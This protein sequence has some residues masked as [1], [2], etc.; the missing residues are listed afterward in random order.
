VGFIAQKFGAPQPDR[1]V[2]DAHRASRELWRE[3][4]GRD[5]VVKEDAF[6]GRQRP[7]PG[8]TY[9][10]SA[11]SGASIKRLLEAFRSMAP[12]GWSDDR[13]E[14]SRHYVG[15]AYVAIH[16]CAEQMQQG[17][18]QVFIKDPSHP[19]GKRPVTPHDPPQGG[20]AVRPYDLVE[21][22]EKPNPDDS[23]GDLMY[24]WYCQMSLTGMTLTWMVPNSIPAEMRGPS[25]CELYPVPTALAIPQPAVNPD[26]PDGYYRIQPVYPY[27]PFS[28]YPTPNSA[29]G[30]AIPAQWMLR[31]KY[32][33]PF[34]RYDGYSPMTALRYHL[35]L[36]EMID[37]SRHYSMRRS[38]SPSAVL[39]FGE[40]EGA[41]PLPE[42]E[43]ERVR[44]E[45]EELH[46]G[47][48]NAGALFVSPPGGKLE[49]WGIRPAD[50][51]YP[52]GWDQQVS[53]VLGGFGITKP[54]AGM[55]DD[56]SYS[57]LFATMKQLYWQTLDPSCHRFSTHLTRRLAPFFGDD[58]IVEV[59]CRRIDD[60]D[61]QLAKLNT[62]ASQR[63][64]TKNELRREL[65][66]P[67][68]RESWGND[69]CG[70]VTEEEMAGGKGAGSLPKGTQDGDSGAVG[71]REQEAMRIL[72]AEV[73][74]GRPDP[75]K[76]GLGAAG[77]FDQS[78]V[79][80]KKDLAAALDHVRRIR[81]VQRNGH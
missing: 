47:P 58:L 19:D 45:M 15:I 57:T 40:M 26:Y 75:G 29:V 48:E 37:R 51:D 21:L 39:N 43:I 68:T 44:A 79:D 54:A 4:F 71:G 65:E 77:G 81:D 46:Q 20:R 69:L 12:G 25:P 27:G 66:M 41:Q 7:V 34:L 5:S 9:A 78:G 76:L 16:R 32:P 24:N 33:H 60:H 18:F 13:W 11:A 28:S 80:R 3:V 74:A 70:V 10:R 31:M 63:A 36:V 23:F 17:E 8:G 59:R 73:S 6:A 61:V 30:A 38:I 55:V 22:L 1:P 2:A 14:Q 35:D 49:Q 52:R 64:L 72:P 56:S 62:A 50:M 67:L 53:F 42:E